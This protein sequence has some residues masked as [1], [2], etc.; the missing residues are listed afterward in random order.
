MLDSGV[1]WRRH[2]TSLSRHFYLAPHSLKLDE[3]SAA[4]TMA[5]TTR[6]DRF[7]HSLNHVGAHP[8]QLPT[9]LLFRL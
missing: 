1:L 3:M 7:Q 4:E 9:V 5:T 8:H 2:L 6:P